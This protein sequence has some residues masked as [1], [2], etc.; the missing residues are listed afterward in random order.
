M[1]SNYLLKKFIYYKIWF[2]LIHTHTLHLLT[3]KSLTR[4]NFT[5]LSYLSVLSSNLPLPQRSVYCPSSG[6]RVLSILLVT[7]TE[8]SLTVE[9]KVKFSSSMCECTCWACNALGKSWCCGNIW[10]KKN[11]SYGEFTLAMKA[12]TSFMYFLEGAI[13]KGLVL[14]TPW[15]S[16]IVQIKST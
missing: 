6:S 8:P 2:I 15:N 9:C 14:L 3:Y 13:Q 7:T 4:I 12:I 1:F 5:V 10:K 16:K 11:W